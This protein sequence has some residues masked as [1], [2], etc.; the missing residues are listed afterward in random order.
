MN[1]LSMHNLRI[2]LLGRFEPVKSLWRVL[3]LGLILYIEGRLLYPCIL[4]YLH[5]FMFYYAYAIISTSSYL[6]NLY[7]TTFIY[8]L[9]HI[10]IQITIIIH[11][12]LI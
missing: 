6:I 1:I 12:W 4:Y 9:V 2:F 3:Q 5:S 11:H 8:S 7:Y 10:I